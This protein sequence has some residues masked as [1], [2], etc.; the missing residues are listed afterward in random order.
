MDPFAVFM[1]G[2]MALFVLFIVLLGLF[3][4]RSGADTVKWRPTRSYE[5][6]VAAE[7]DDLDQM[8]EATNARRRER[9]ES[10][11]TEH[12]LHERVQADRTEGETR[13]EAYLAD[14]EIDELVAHRNERRAKKGLPAMS[15]AE[16]EAEVSKWRAS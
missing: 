1:F 3:H 2:G 11:L 15:R 9:G 10:E 12:A 14:R 13:R 16:V 7:I 4:P 6:Q 8:L 5:D